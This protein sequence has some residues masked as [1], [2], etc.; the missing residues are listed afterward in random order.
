MGIGD[1]LTKY[2]TV[3]AFVVVIVILGLCGWIWVQ[4]NTIDSLT[5]KNQA[6]ARTIDTQSKTITKLKADAAL[7]RKLTDEITKAEAEARSKS[8][9][10]IKSIPHEI[11][12]S[13][14]Y[15]ADAPRN[16]IE[17]LQQ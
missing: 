13:N 10:V 7:N 9:D 2:F 1:L 5:A 6:Q 4:S 11:K 3:I 14:P 15:N 8:D 17:F 16:V 12:Q